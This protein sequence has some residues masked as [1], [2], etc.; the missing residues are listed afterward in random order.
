[1]GYRVGRECFIKLMEEG[2]SLII[3]YPTGGV[4]RTS[5]V[6]EVEQTDYG[7]WVTTNNRTYRFDVDAF[8]KKE[9]LNDTRDT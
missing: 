4:F 6:K 3:E 2:K 7:F 9:K 5:I 1:M 8:Y